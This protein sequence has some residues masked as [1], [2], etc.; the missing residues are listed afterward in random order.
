M[1]PAQA[2]E[3]I[4]RVGALAIALGIG[5]LVAVTPWVASADDSA[6]TTATSSTSATPRSGARE[7]TAAA[8]PANRVPRGRN[9]PAAAAAQRSTTN[10]S[11]AQPGGPVPEVSV[12]QAAASFTPPALP[13][14]AVATPVA[15]TP[16]VSTAAAA[17]IAPATVPAVAARP[18]AAVASFVASAVTAPAGGSTGTP[19][20]PLDFVTGALSLVSSE[21]NRTSR[22]L[23]G[24][25]AAAG[26]A[27]PAPAATT[28][29]ASA[30]YSV[31]S[32]WGS[33]FT[34]TVNLTAGPSALNG[35]TVSFTTPAEIT[36]VWNGVITSHVGTAYV[37]TNAAWNGQVAAGASTSFGFQATTGAAGSAVT[38]LQLN[39]VA[40]PTPT[41]TQP[42]ASV[43]NVTVAEPASG[44]AQAA[45]TVTLSK[46]STTPVTIGYATAN[47]TATAGAD[48]TATTG[49]LSFAPGV[50][51]QQISVPVLADTITEPTETFTVTLSNPSGATITTATATGTITDTPPKSGSPSASYTA[52]DNW[53]SGFTGTVNLTA[54]PSA[55]NGW[56]V[57]FTT[58][59]EIT[60]VW[61]GVITSHVGTAY[62][63]TNAAWNGQVAAGASTSFGFQATTGAAG[64][65]VTG[66]QLN[67][68]ASPTPTTTQPTASVGNVTV[69]EPASGTAQAAFTVT[70]SKASTT[71]VTIGY[72]TA[73][74]TATAGADYTATTGTLSFAPGV[75]SQQISV[76]VLLDTIVE[77]SET[78]TVTLS[79][80]SGATITT[81]TA[82]GTITNTV[83]TAVGTAP[84]ISLADAVVTEGNS[85]TSNLAFTATLS[86]ASA[87]A[88][89]VK[90]A[91]SNGTATA[92]QDYTAGSGTITFAPGVTSQTVNVAVT[93]DTTVEP[94]ETLTVTLSTPSGATIARAVATGTIVTDDFAAQTGGTTAQWGNAFFAPYVDMAGWPVPDLV[95]M[96][97]ATGA[98]LF[99]LGFLQADA[100][101]KAAWGS[102]TVLEPTSTDAQAVAINKSIATFRAAGGDVMISFGGVAGT[103]LAQYYAAKGLSAQELANAYS[104]VIDT[105]GVTHL[106]FDIEGA[107]IADAAAIALNSSA[108][109]LLQQSRPSVQIW[110]T[111]PVLPQGLTS[112]GI[113]VVQAALTAGVKLAGVNVMAMDYGEGP[114]PTSG[115]GAQTMG[116]YAIQSAQSTYTQL[117]S[118]YTKNGQT[119]SWNQIGVTPMIGVNDITSEVFT[120][121][122][123]Q[124]L[125]SFAVTKGLGMLGYWSVERDYPGTLGQPTHN[126]SGVSSPAGSFSGAFNQYGTINVLSTNTTSPTPTPAPTG[127]VISAQYGTTV[128]GGKYV[129]Q[130]NAWNN[131]SGQ[132]ITV[133]PTGFA[134]TAESGSAPTNGAP[135]AYPSIYIGCHYGNCSPGAA[136]VQ[137]SQIHTATSSISYT[138][139]SGIYDASYDIWLNPTPITTGVNKQEVMIWLNRQGSI[140]PVGSV[141][142][143]VAIGGQTWAVWQG[144]NGGNDVI[145]YVAPSPISSADFNLLSFVSD[146]EGRS[147]VTN[148]WYLTS[149]QAGFEPWTGGVG[150]AVNS[151]TASIT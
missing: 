108:L 79:N 118:V 67:G 17:S 91:T 39:G 140:Q 111:L 134:I 18:T 83:P 73:N 138:Y 150:L 147:T 96:S 52:G 122:D 100:N 41:T 21:I 8:A 64:S 16:A 29:P 149:I 136:P 19:A 33:G 89:T 75:T 99:T 50:T 38:G 92:G 2:S 121:A 4:G 22:R 61:N 142:G 109:K 74:G 84:T 31:A 20:G 120:V 49:T 58:P 63:V 70:L 11:P 13:A 46:A 143:S 78:F 23:R 116:T 127:T 151:F 32:D 106:D 145:S 86:K 94:T 103:S 34:G 87:T 125:D 37:V 101:G 60:N 51:S 53:G 117:S 30:T 66:L 112:D 113:N 15:V 27:T 129:V 130:N 135:L 107:A 44:T 88:V 48:Y 132:T 144:S 25:L 36:N 85:G 28:G 42:T 47:G 26:T 24:A 126:A 45:F 137:V 14:T 62:V 76:P 148:S 55:L 98:S 80:P 12:A 133:T 54:G 43:G 56:T 115:T 57:S 90:Y 1:F 59:A 110:Y 97:K 128:I 119:L 146:V 40:S 68:V 102:Y 139:A 7:Q 69:A 104:G 72:A 5:G 124:A 77:P 65:A 131:G 81:A 10:S 35:W 114:A 105:Y 6:S 82:T 141:V 9:A 71:P 123:A 93:G 3:L 95:A